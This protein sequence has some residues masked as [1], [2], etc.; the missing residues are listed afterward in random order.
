MAKNTARSCVKEDKRIGA[1]IKIHRRAK[2]ISQ[3]ILGKALGITFQ[4]VQKYEKGTNR[5]G[6]A[7]L[8]QI[9]EFLEVS[10]DDL[11]G[12]DPQETRGDVGELMA[13]LGAPQGI[14]LARMIVKLTVPQRDALG[15]FVERML[16]AS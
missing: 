16:A 4:Q 2:H 7:R 11:L 3:D 9:S 13:C 10:T 12:G 15:D 14:R 5:V 6:A 1:R 8:K